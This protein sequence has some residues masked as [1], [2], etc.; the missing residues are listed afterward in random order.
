MRLVLRFLHD[1]RFPS[2]RRG[3]PLPAA[4]FHLCDARFQAFKSIYSICYL[5]CTTGNH[6]FDR[7]SGHDDWSSG[8]SLS[9]PFRPLPRSPDQSRAPH[10]TAFRCW[11][12]A[13]R[14]YINTD[15]VAASWIQDQHRPP[16][17][18]KPPCGHRSPT[19]GLKQFWEAALQLQYPRYRNYPHVRESR[20]VTNGFAGFSSPCLRTG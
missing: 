17:S 6:E 9:C 18:P 8:V 7:I 19:C 2:L 16:A 14:Q 15:P 13:I 10:S 12:P 1:S 4:Q 20:A 3:E 5:R 11:Y